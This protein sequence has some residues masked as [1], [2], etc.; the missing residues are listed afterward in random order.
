MHLRNFSSVFLLFIVAFPSPGSPCLFSILYRIR[1][2]LF[3]GSFLWVLETLLYP[4]LLKQTWCWKHILMCLPDVLFFSPSSG[5]FLPLSSFFH[6]HQFPCL[7]LTSLSFEFYLL[8]ACELHGAVLH[9]TNTG[10]C[11]MLS[12]QFSVSKIWIIAWRIEESRCCFCSFTSFLA[13][14]DKLLSVIDELG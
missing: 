8:W 9:A 11:Q 6:L 14:L 5:C 7:V 13:D 4:S 10:C 3:M 1:L 2:V 12:L